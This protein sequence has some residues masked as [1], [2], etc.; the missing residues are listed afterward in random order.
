MTFL[1][2]LFFQVLKAQNNPYTK[3]HIL[4]DIFVTFQHTQVFTIDFLFYVY[5]MLIDHR[6][7]V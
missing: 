4:G 1:Y 5:I 7:Q 6:G 2:L 3:G